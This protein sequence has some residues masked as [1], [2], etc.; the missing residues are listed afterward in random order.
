[1]KI[2]I[3]LFLVTQALDVATT[4]VGM[5]A[6]LREGNPLVLRMMEVFGPIWPL[7]KIA[8]LCALAAAFWWF[9]APEGIWAMAVA[10]A[11]IVAWNVRKIDG[12]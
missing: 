1:M 4:I 9:D 6:G 11:I 2:A 5:R 8:P 3:I 7:A 12:L 10:G